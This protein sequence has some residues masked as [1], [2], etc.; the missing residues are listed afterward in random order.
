[1]FG[2]YKKLLFSVAAFAAVVYALS[3]VPKNNDG[4]NISSKSIKVKAEKISEKER[5]EYHLKNPFTEQDLMPFSVQSDSAILF[6]TE[7]GKVLYAKYINEEK[8]TASISKIMTAVVAVENSKPDKLITISKTAAEQIPNKLGLK[9]GER[10]KAE[11]L[12]YT[13]MML[14]ANDSAYALAEG[15]LGYN[16]FVKAMNEKAAWLEL[17]NTI[18]T[19]P[20][21]LDDPNHKSSAYDLGVITRYALKKH[22]EILKYMGTI[23]YSISETDRNPA[24]YAYHISDMIKSYPG[25]DGAKTGYTWEAGHTFLGTAQRNGK[26]LVVIVFNSQDPNGDIRT[27]L[28]YGF[29]NR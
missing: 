8:Q 2:K 29:N 16:N 1:M 28:D 23:D 12:L 18:F 24:H 17:K 10:I 15:T 19:N 22:P 3:F 20:A 14:S 13:M 4:I 9:E 5:D 27:L 26:R 6:E 25:M 7:T 21:G 11:D